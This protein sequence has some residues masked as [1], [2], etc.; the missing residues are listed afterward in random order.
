MRQEATEN[1]CWDLSGLYR[2]ADDAQ[3]SADLAALQDEAL[4]LR[5]TFHGKLKSDDLTAAELVAALQA[6]EAMQRRGLKACCYAQLLFAADSGSERNKALQ[7]QA[8]EAWTT[9]SEATLFIE[10]ELAQLDSGTFAQLLAEPELVPYRHYLR[11][12]RAHAPYTLP[13]A[14]EQ[15]L[16]RKDLSGREAFAQLFEELTS[17]WLFHV[18]SPDG[19]SEE[20]LSG[21]E[22]LARLY[23]PLPDVRE[24]AFTTFL[25]RHRDH[26]LVLCACF[27]NLLLDHGKEAELRGY[28]EPMTPTHL[29]CETDPGMVEQ[30]LAV[31]EAHYGLAREYFELKR[32]LLGLQR[33]KNTDLYAPLPGMTRMIPFAEAKEIVLDTFHDFAPQLGDCAERFFSEGRID[34]RPRPGKG[35]GAFC[36]GMYPGVAPY[37]L[38]NYTGTPRD[39]STLA[40]ELGHGVHFSLAQRNNLFNYQGSLPLAETA[41]VFAEMLLARR[42]L[43]HEEVRENKIALLCANLEDIIATTFRQTLLT[44]FELAAHRRR[45]AGLLAAEDFCRLW[46]EENAKLFGDSVEMIEA[47]RWGWSYIGHFIHSRFYCFSYVFGE[48]LSLALYQRYRADGQGF[49]PL[50]LELLAKG[51]SES[52]EALLAPFGIDLHVAAFWEQGY[53]PVREMLDELRHL[54]DE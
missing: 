10:L 41:S 8:Q 25:E 54:D 52:P 7:A 16:R 43:A 22:L 30:M 38:L 9:A 29:A 5:Q 11:Q 37:I 44:R 33:M 6:Y 3:W 42:L 46:W 26:A 45:Q 49:V 24:A 14:V 19:A 50:Y 47:Y 31:S 1:E 40:H 12:L 35:G 13:E 48:L 20:E 2:D 28:P 39:V 27:N 32:R 53:V 23:H 18:R 17:S 34:V 51:G 36:H 21:E 15:A 4:R